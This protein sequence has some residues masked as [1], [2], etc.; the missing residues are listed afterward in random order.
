ME[1]HLNSPLGGQLM[2][3][4]VPSERALELQAQSRDWPSWGL[5]PRQ[6]CDL[7]LLL[8]G[9]FSPLSSFMSKADYE[10]V[11]TQMRLPDG[12]IWPIPVVLDISNKF[13]RAIGCNDS[14]ALRDPEGVMLAAMHIEG[15]WQPDRL[16][17]AEAIYGTTS[18]E[19]PGVKYLLEK[20]CPWYVE[21]RIEGIQLPLHYDSRD[22][23]H[24]PSELR[25]EFARHGWHRIVAFHTSN[26]IHRADYELTQQAAQKVGANLLVHPSVELTRPD[27][28]DHYVRVR[29]Y[30]ALVSKY[31]GDIK[32]SLVPLATRMGGPR[33]AVW[34]A[35]VRKNYG[36]SH[37]IVGQDH[38]S[39][40]HNKTGKSFYERYAAQEMLSMHENE[41]GI[42]MV[43]A[44]M[45]ADLENQEAQLPEGAVTF[46]FHAVTCSTTIVR[47]CLEEGRQIPSW[48]TFPEVAQ[49]LQ[50]SYP[51]KHRQGFTVL[52]TGL[53]G[54]GKSTI[55]NVLLV[56]LL[57]RG[58]RPVT[59]LDGDIVRKLLS[60]GLGFSRDDR[61][62]NIRR[63]GFVASEVTK[64]GGIAICAPIAPYDEVRKNVRSMIQPHGG[65]VLVYLCTPLEVCESR[66]RK[67][68]YARARAGIVQQFTGISD[69][70]EIPEDAD[71]VIDTSALS[72]EEA[73]L[74]ILL[75]LEGRGYIEAPCQDSSKSI[76]RDQQKLKFAHSA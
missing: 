43:P 1:D 52:F 50:R 51:P 61:D 31:F 7:E 14:I 36:C 38:G 74:K 32:L 34:H 37:L 3:L 16:A 63:I 64:N 8:N 75:H 68:L 66:D 35:I 60:S 48:L 20:T 47:T 25:A 9:G 23:R 46:D 26:P 45:I 15:V 65:F 57:E 55:A 19:H 12:Q 70:Y 21:G 22:L 29:C 41:I 6:L 54:S 24:T 13:V 33:E 76:F 49:E 69:P 59:L 72:P 30:R 73:A 2:N 71:A 42:K 11:C 39:P 27:D 17:E 40:D 58:G 56:K 53:S 28:L 5:V 4:I 10:G 67:G 18:T 62:L 44:R